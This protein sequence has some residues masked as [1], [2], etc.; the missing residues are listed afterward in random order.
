M[1]VSEEGERAGGQRGALTSRHCQPSCFTGG[2]RGN[3]MR[4][5]KSEY[6]EN[7]ISALTTPSLIR[8]IRAN[9]ERIVIAHR[10]RWGD[11]HAEISIATF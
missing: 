8:R 6:M 7:I 5:L 10:L 4:Y 3:A 11:T 1:R 9:F 2:E